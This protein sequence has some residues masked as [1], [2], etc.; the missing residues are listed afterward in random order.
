MRM[1]WARDVSGRGHVGVYCSGWSLELELPRA[2]ALHTGGAPMCT[3]LPNASSSSS[4]PSLPPVPASAC[5]DDRRTAF[6]LST[7][8]SGGANTPEEERMLRPCFGE[9]ISQLWP[10]PPLYVSKY[11]PEHRSA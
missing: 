7:W 6:A 2:R 1:Q 10:S 5:T 4:P 3:P 11:E 8:W 9:T